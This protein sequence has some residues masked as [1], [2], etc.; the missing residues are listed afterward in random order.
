MSQQQ[1]RA[2]VADVE[3]CQDGIQ[4]VT[5]VSITRRA[6]PCWFGFAPGGIRR[7][8]YQDIREDALIMWRDVAPES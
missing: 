4:L 5:S 2:R 8:Y 1:G 3:D 6:A 7:N